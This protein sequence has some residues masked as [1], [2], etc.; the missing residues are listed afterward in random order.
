MARDP[1]NLTGVL[2]IDAGIA[3][4]FLGL[5][6]L[7]WPL[8]FLG[9]RSRR[10]GAFWL[11]SGALLG[12]AGVALPAPL[13]RGAGRLSRL[14]D[15]VPAYQFVEHH[16]IRIQASP[17]RV[18]AAVWAV[19][20]E[21]MRIFQA[22]TWIRS[23]RLPW[24]RCGR[25][26]I[27]NAPAQKPILE[28]ATS[29]GFML[30]ADEPGRE[31]VVGMLV[32]VPSRSRAVIATPQDFAALE[33][34]GFAKAVMNFRMQ[35]DGGGWTR[36]TTETRIYATDASSRR[37]FAAYWRTICPGSALIRRAWLRAIRLR[38]EAPVTVER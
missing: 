29:S 32:V 21:E 6:S 17:L 15:I 35:D 7:V 8:R 4:S 19:T 36:L 12:L 1:V 23:P 3:A 2:L 14:D 10:R 37:R 31:V 24:G 22:L 20:P 9:I 18:H 11:A 16:E 30:L 38:A 28:V 33:E 34:P 5:V 26:S 27:L 13:R 25:E